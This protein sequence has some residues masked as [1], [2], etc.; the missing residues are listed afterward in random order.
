M[1][2]FQD[3]LY[4]NTWGLCCNIDGDGDGEGY[5]DDEARFLFN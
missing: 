5:D 1:A 3:I 2:S 4:A